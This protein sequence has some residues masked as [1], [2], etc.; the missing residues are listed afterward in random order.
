MA[1]VPLVPHPPV[2]VPRPPVYVPMCMRSHLVCACIVHTALKT[3]QSGQNLTSW[4]TC[5][6]P[7]LLLCNLCCTCTCVCCELA[8]LLISFHFHERNI[9]NDRERCRHL[10]RVYFVGVTLNVCS[11]AHSVEIEPV[12]VLRGR[13][14]RN[15]KDEG[16]S[17]DLVSYLESKKC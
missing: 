16:F 12:R 7:V 4:T 5:Y 3:A 11:C 17:F 6:G 9:T 8:Q 10:L 15:S 2:Y 13:E 14:R 1:S